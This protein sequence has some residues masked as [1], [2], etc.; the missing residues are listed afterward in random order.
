MSYNR[1]LDLLAVS[2]AATQAGLPVKAAKFMQAAAKDPSA[3]AAIEAICAANKKKTKPKKKAKASYA[4]TIFA[5]VED[6][7][8]PD[9]ETADSDGEAVDD[10]EVMKVEPSETARMLRAALRAGADY[11]CDDEDSEEVAGE[12]E[13]IG[14]T[15]KP[16]PVKAKAGGRA[17]AM[18]ELEGDMAELEPNEVGADGMI[19]P[20][21]NMESARFAR[22]LRNLAARQGK[23]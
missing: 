5:G 6:D 16:K 12:E 9:E 4:S 18:P 14:A 19:E 11:V 3:T 15:A 1:T 23:K 8:M 13:P 20:K 22:T 7:E 17:S 2:L 21:V 10:E